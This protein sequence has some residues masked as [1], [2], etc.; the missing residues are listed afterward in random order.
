MHVQGLIFPGAVVFSSYL[1]KKNAWILD[2]WRLR[3]G[4]PSTCAC[5]RVVWCCAVGSLSEL[6]QSCLNSQDGGSSQGSLTVFVSSASVPS[7]RRTDWMSS[8]READADCFWFLWRCRERGGFNLAYKLEAWGLTLDHC[9]S[10]REF[11]EK[12]TCSD[13]DQSPTRQ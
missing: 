9:C 1:I 12:R 11:R 10:G 4:V 2:D 3:C 7:W 6:L 13:R 5:T 8:S